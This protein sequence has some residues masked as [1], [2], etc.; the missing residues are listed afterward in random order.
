MREPIY[1]KRKRDNLRQRG[2]QKRMYA[3]W[4]PWRGPTLQ[5]YYVARICVGCHSPTPRSMSGKRKYITN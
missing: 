1:W 5:S 3:Y 4:C 2:V